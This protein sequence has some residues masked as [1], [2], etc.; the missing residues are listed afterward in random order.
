MLFDTLD[1]GRDLM[2][3]PPLHLYTIVTDHIIFYNL[4]L[5]F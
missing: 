2:I 4:I 5:H 1:V 3:P